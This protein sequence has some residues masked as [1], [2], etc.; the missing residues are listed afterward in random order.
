MTQQLP[1]EAVIRQ[2]AERAT[3]SGGFEPSGPVSI[4]SLHPVPLVSGSQT[5]TLFLQL[6]MH[7]VAFGELPESV[8]SLPEAHPA[9]RCRR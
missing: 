7:G 2:I 9:R 1:E 4:L 8:S 6:A 3:R 5:A